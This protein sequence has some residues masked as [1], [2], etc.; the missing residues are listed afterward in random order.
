LKPKLLKAI[1]LK[2][3]TSNSFMMRAML[4]L[5]VVPF[6]LLKQFSPTRTI[7]TYEFWEESLINNK[8]RKEVG[9][10]LIE[11]HAS[12]S[13][14]KWSGSDLFFVEMGDQNNSAWGNDYY[15]ITGDF[16]ISYTVPK[17]IQGKYKVF[18][19]A[20]AFNSQNAVIEVFIDGKKMGSLIDLTRGGSANY[21]FSR[22]ELG[23]ID[24]KK[25]SEHVIEVKPLIPGRFLWDYIRFEPI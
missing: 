21:P 11:D 14:V 5:K 10:H 9:T 16:T 3:T 20:E 25:Y 22:I 8:F 18:L 1:P 23:T 2:S 12:L 13:T 19:G 6:I 17:I 15:S 7:V 24:F 4:S